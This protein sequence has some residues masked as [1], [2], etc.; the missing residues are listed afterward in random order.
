M[1]CSPTVA[2]GPTSGGSATHRRR[3]GSGR[4]GVGGGRDAPS[5]RRLW[6]AGHWGKRKGRRGRGRNVHRRN[7]HIRER[8]YR[9]HDHGQ[10]GRQAR[11]TCE[12]WQDPRCDPIGVGHRAGQAR[13]V[14]HLRPSSPGR[15]HVLPA[16][17]GQAHVRRQGHAEQIGP[18]RDAVDEGYRPAVGDDDGGSRG[19]SGRGDQQRDC[20]KPDKG[21]RRRCHGCLTHTTRPRSRFGQDRTRS[22]FDGRVTGPNRWKRAA[23]SRDTPGH[24]HR[25][26]RTDQCWN[27][28]TPAPTTQIA[29]RANKD[30]TLRAIGRSSLAAAVAIG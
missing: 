3:I 1:I 18:G 12:R 14:E 30:G 8:D 23:D 16:G 17:H 29:I 28:P 24:T 15:E 22:R 13:G 9:V 26:R 20:Q 25:V 21:T 5:A 2:V 10:G 4:H 27:R 7:R 6:Q 19:G 11:Q